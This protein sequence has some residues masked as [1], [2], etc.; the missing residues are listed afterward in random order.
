MGVLSLLWT[1]AATVSP[2]QEGVAGDWPIPYRPPAA[3]S[4]YQPRDTTR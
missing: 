3:R 4:A 1:D 2:W